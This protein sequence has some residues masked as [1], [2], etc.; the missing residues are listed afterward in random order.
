MATFTPSGAQAQTLSTIKAGMYPCEIVGAVAKV[1]KDGRFEQHSLRV[2]VF[3]ETSDDWEDF[4]EL[5][6]FSTKAQWKLEEVM[7]SLGMGFTIGVSMDV[8]D[9][10]WL[11]RTG[12]VVLKEDNQ[13]PLKRLR[14]GRWVARDG[15]PAGPAR[16]ERG[17]ASGDADFDGIPF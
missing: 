6:T 7:Q 15:E 5:L 13:G 2:R 1:S 10:D 16:V 12:R 8:E 14:I 9:G 3:D 4:W 11:G 17:G